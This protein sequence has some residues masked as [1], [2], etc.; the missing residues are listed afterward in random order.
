MG[1]V[2]S[3]HVSLS[4]G[5][6]VKEIKVVGMRGDTNTMPF[7]YNTSMED[8]S[9]MVPG[10]LFHSK[11]IGDALVKF[12]ELEQKIIELG[13]VRCT[14]KEELTWLVRH[15]YL[16]SSERHIHLFPCHNLVVIGGDMDKELVGGLVESLT[17]R[18]PPPPQDEASTFDNPYP[19]SIPK[20]PIPKDVLHDPY[21]ITS[22][23][24]YLGGTTWEKQEKALWVFKRSPPISTH[25]N[26]R[27]VHDSTIENM[28]KHLSG[29]VGF[30]W[31][32]LSKEPSMDIIMEPTSFAQYVSFL[33]VRLVCEGEW[34]CEMVCGVVCLGW[35][36]HTCHHASSPH[37]TCTITSSIPTTCQLFVGEG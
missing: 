37:L 7:F 35:A 5:N 33:L 15:I 4:K 18:L 14:T 9:W 19:T 29:L 27:K 12:E 24:P 17:T 11:C 34:P 26:V 1:G 23:H 32:F 8:A 36:N 2:A 21:S 3:S 6:H 13:G 22:I 20:C 16:P 28:V 31:R 30:G 25:G 10:K